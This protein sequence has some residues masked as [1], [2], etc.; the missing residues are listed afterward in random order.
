VEPPGEA[1]PEACGDPASRR[2]HPGRRSRST[3]LL[4]GLTAAVCVVRSLPSRQLLPVSLLCGSF[5]PGET[6]LLCLPRC[7]YRVGAPESGADEGIL[8][9]VTVPASTSTV[10]RNEPGPPPLRRSS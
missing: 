9:S 6:S 8:A 5:G 1:A 2:M 3:P 7:D 10:S 4:L